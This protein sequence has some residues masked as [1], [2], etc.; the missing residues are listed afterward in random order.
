MICPSCELA[1]NQDKLEN[2][3]ITS[4]EKFDCDIC[5]EELMYFENEDGKFNSPKKVELA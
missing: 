5:Q 1:I 4:G 3:N 2:N